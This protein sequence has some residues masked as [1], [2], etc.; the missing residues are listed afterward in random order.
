MEEEPT[1]GKGLAAHSTLPAKLGELTDAVAENLEVHMTAL[2]LEDENARREHAAYESLAREH[3]AIAARL[4]ALGEEMA[5]YR[6]LPMGRHDMTAMSSPPVLAAFTTLVR[7]EQELLTL[8]QEREA[9]NREMLAAMGAADD[10][11]S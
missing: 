1:C 8:L 9:L 11:R 6:D 2:D 3:R 10:R 5:G 4:R 7:V